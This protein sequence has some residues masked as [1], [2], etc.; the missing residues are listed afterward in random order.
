MTLL[1][2]LQLE[3]IISFRSRIASQIKELRSF[4]VSL[5]FLVVVGIVDN[6]KTATRKYFHFKKIQ[7]KMMRQQF[8][9]PAQYECLVPTFV[10]LREIPNISPRVHQYILQHSKLVNLTILLVN[11][12]LG[13]YV[14]ST[15]QKQLVLDKCPL[16]TTLPYIQWGRCLI[17]IDILLELL[18][19]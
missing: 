8:R 3:F 15:Y 11:I 17:R 7:I 19:H 14:F 12:L 4:V 13:Y 2:L 6:M 10:E 18:T 5:G 9:C 1:L 16:T